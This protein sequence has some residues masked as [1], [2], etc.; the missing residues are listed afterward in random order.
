VGIAREA[1]LDRLLASCNDGDLFLLIRRGFSGPMDPGWQVP[2]AFARH[3]EE[4]VRDAT[5]GRIGAVVGRVTRR[6]KSG[7]TI[8]A[9]SDVGPEPSDPSRP[10]DR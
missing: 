4:R 10:S 6:P 8:L 2:A 5:P 9:Q 7:P 3:A 1:R